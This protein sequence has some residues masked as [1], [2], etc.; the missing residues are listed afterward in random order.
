MKESNPLVFLDSIDS[1]SVEEL[2][3]EMSQNFRALFITKSLILPIACMFF[4]GTPAVWFETVAEPY[5]YRWNNFRSSLEINFGSFGAYWERRMVNKF[6]NYTSDSNNGGFGCEEGTSPSNV[7]DREVG[8]DDD[9]D[10]ND[11][12][13]G[14]DDSDSDDDEDPEE[15][16]EKESD[17]DKT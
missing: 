5:L 7:P 6:G 12:D 8:D 15:D 1:M 2:T 14:S 10:G 4:M 9:D 17:R 3:I 16:L 11:D 13:S